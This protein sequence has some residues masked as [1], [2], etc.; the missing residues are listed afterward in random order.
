[1]KEFTGI[2]NLTLA[3]SRIQ[4]SG[5]AREYL[6]NASRP[7]TN[8]APWVLNLALDYAGSRGTTVR[9]L[10]NVAGKRIVQVGSQDIPDA[11]EHPGT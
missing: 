4:L 8:Q 1:M 3:Q 11:Y 5:A 10:Y 6:T 2:A 7:M 9:L